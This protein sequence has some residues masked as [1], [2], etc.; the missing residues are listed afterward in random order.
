M[1]VLADEKEAG[2]VWNRNIQ[3]GAKRKSPNDSRGGQSRLQRREE[4]LIHSRP[5]E[6]QN[7][8][9]RLSL[10]RKVDGF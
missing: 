2:E 6:R 10:M 7:S 5:Q 4:R 1:M 8:A 3:Q 9:Q